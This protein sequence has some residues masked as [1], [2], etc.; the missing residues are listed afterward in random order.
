LLNQDKDS[1]LA[2]DCMPLMDEAGPLPMTGVRHW[3]FAELTIDVLIDLAP[4]Q[5]YLPLFA[6]GYDAMSAVEALET[7][8]YCGEITVIA[9][10]LPRPR[11]VERELRALGPG[12]RLTLISP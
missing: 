8:G 10:D 6:S 5:I 11:L 3:R 9:P 2:L 12:L 1:V 4:S 7:M